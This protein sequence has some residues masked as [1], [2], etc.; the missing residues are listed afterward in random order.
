M[1]SA[2]MKSI[3][4]LMAKLEDKK[5]AVAALGELATLSQDNGAAPFLIKALPKLLEVSAHKEKAIASAAYK[6]VEMFLTSLSPHAVGIV[7]PVLIE[8][9]GTKKKPE[10]KACALKMLTALAKTHPNHMAWCLVDVLPPALSLLTDVKKNVAD[11]ALEASTEMSSVSGNKDVAPFISEMMG[12]V[13]KPASIGDVV[14]KLASVVFVQAVET[15]ALAVTCP[16]VMRG[17]KDRKEPTQ[18]KAC[19]II[20][21][22]VKLV[23]DP[24]EV[25]P[26]LAQLLPQLEKVKDAMS[27][28]EARGMAERAYKTL[29]TAQE[30]SEMRAADPEAVKKVVVDAVG[31]NYP[32]DAVGDVTMFVVGMS[33]AIS[34]TRVFSK[35]VWVDAFAGLQLPV[36]VAEAAMDVCFKAAN[37]VEA[38]DIE[39]EA[40]DDLCNC[41]FTLGYGSLTLLNNTRLYLKRGMNYGLLGPN[42]CGKTTLM[43]AINNEQVDGFPPKS[44]LRTAFVEHGIGEAEPECDWLPIDY[45]MDEPCIKADVDAGILTK[46]FMIE[47]LQDVGF[48]SGDKLDMTLGKLSGGWK[49]KMGL[50]R[51]MLM[52][53]DILMMDEPTGHLDKFNCAWL[54]DYVNSLKKGEKPVTVIATSHDS[55]FLEKTTTHILDFQNRKL[56]L[57]KGTLSTFVEKV[58]EAK[59]YFEIK[60]AKTKFVFPEPGFLEGVKSKSKALLKMSNVEFTY[61]GK[62]KP[63]LYGVGVQVSMLSRVAIVG[64]NGAGKS[65]M[66]KC[67]LGELK[68]T[69]GTI[70]KVQGCRIAYMAQ[71]AF[72]H[73]E[74]HLDKSAT[75]YVL[76]RF[77]GGEDNESLEYLAALGATKA[78]D[79]EKVKK[80]KWKD[81]SLIEVETFYNDKG[82]LE[83]QKKDLDKAVALDQIVQRRKGKKE[84]EYECKWVGMSAES[85]TW[86]DRPTLV[87]MGYKKEVQREDEKQ[88][89]M[90]GLQNKLLTTPGVEAHLA[91]FGVP[92]EFAT[93]NTLKSLSAGMKVKVVLGAAMWQ[94]PHILVIDEPTNYLDRDALGALTEAIENYGGGVVVISHNLAFCE[95]VATEKWIMDAGHLRAE[96]GEY[97]DVKIEEKALDDEITDAAG[98]KI[99][100]KRQKELNSK[101]LKKAIKDIEKKLKDNKKSKMLSEDELYA[102]EDQLA[103]LKEKMK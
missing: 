30:T 6:A 59:N 65:T 99:D 55:E 92:A 90:Q 69:S 75:Q 27:D 34:N 10:E 103:E 87:A 86:V 77:A 29:T 22:M 20:D 83:Y 94:N 78:T 47:K 32:Y 1:V 38:D 15:P 85:L 18:R 79:E 56:K 48:K 97:V 81:G 95:R 93:H 4:G 8:S 42:D 13:Q 66:I 9:L 62:E 74:E 24:R 3:T 89:A 11:A 101:E 25:L 23:P 39:D 33:C 91:D 28:P 61:P 63:Q 49:M 17:L 37:A 43:R 58:P 70:M 51:A 5:Q 71:H 98:N 40:G 19:V 16:V 73:L 100:V 54:T 60:S 102:L 31:E 44:E 21:N 7:V 80:M 46:D 68:P 67:L 14:E 82:E 72:H 84:K 64:P 41:V 35:E 76:N 12:A 50:V 88:A 26:F 96:G 36:A 52:K 53:A 45:L 2:V 57:Y